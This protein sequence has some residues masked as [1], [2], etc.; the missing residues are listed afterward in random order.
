MDRAMDTNDWESEHGHIVS[1]EE[2]ERCQVG[3]KSDLSLSG[4]IE[5]PHVALK[6][7]SRSRM[8]MKDSLLHALISLRYEIS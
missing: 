5:I 4:K 2:H 3:L 8:I 1:G 6:S 7:S